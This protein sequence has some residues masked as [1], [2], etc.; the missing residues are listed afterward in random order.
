MHNICKEKIS[1]TFLATN[2]L[3][4]NFV[5]ALQKTQSVGIHD[6]LNAQ[7]F[8]MH[9]RA[10]SNTISHLQVFRCEGILYSKAKGYRLLSFLML[11][12]IEV[13]IFHYVFLEGHND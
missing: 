11:N 8:A 6:V 1:K 7:G 3:A 12:V 4:A 5:Y 10:I 2:F 9:Y 13:K